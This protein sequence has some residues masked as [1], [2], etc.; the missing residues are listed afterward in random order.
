MHRTASI[1]R[2]ILLNVNSSTVKKTSTKLA[3]VLGPSF[4]QCL[5]SCSNKKLVKIYRVDK[6]N[7]AKKAV[8]RKLSWLLVSAVFL[9]YKGFKYSISIL[10]VEVLALNVTMFGNMVFKEVIKVKWGHK[11][12][13]L[14][15]WIDNNFYK[16]DWFYFFNCTCAHNC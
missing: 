16:N 12:R 5:V 15:D 4:G 8:F 1:K 13:G 6:K 10:C 2:I 9:D 7:T 11:G 14:L 3:H